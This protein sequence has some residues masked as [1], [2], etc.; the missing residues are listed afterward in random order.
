[1]IDIAQLDSDHFE[2]KTESIKLLESSFANSCIV[3]V[4]FSDSFFLDRINTALHQGTSRF[5]FAESQNNV[6]DL[7]F[8]YFSIMQNEKKLQMQDMY[9]SQVS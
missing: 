8:K 2:S 7:V 1:M 5:L 9:F 3:F 4:N 6:S